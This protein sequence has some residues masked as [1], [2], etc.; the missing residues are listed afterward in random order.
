MQRP[1]FVVFAALQTFVN[2]LPRLA[3]M[4]CAGAIPFTRCPHGKKHDFGGRWPAD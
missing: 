4:Q 3:A 2:A 1:R